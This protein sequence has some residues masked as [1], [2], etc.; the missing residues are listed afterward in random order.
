MIEFSEKFLTLT[1]D[2]FIVHW[3]VCWVMGV[4]DYFL[5]KTNLWSFVKI[6]PPKVPDTFRGI[7]RLVLF[8][9]IFVSV[10]II[11]AFADRYVGEIDWTTP[12]RVLLMFLLMEVWFYYS[13]RLLHT[14]FL[15]K[16][17]HK[18]HHS[19]SYPLCI[20]TLYAHPIEHGFVNVL[21]VVLPAWI[22]GLPFTLARFWH[23]I[24]LVNSI[25]LSHGGFKWL[26]EQHDVH[27]VYVTINYGV[28]GILDRFHR[29][30]MKNA[31]KKLM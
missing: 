21:A 10:P 12:F 25:L 29:T 4:L 31:K 6:N 8:N 22:V 27:H 1:I 14:R 11:Y 28:L 18:V 5:Y 30:D 17:I 26:C 7:V 19:W 13:H 9:Q 20:S 3:G 23:I 16:Y 2:H 24:A 15:Y